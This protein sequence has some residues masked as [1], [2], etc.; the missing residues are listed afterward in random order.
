MK[1]AGGLWPEIVSFSNL[2]RAAE[3]AAAGKRSRTDVAAFLMNLELELL[4]L[5]RE[6]SQG[7]YLPGKYR[8][9]TLRDPKP[10]LISAAPFR[11]RVVHHALTQVVEPIFERRFST[12]SF[13][14]RVGL[15]THAAVEQA[16][17]GAR[18]FAYVLKCES[19]STSPPSIT[20]S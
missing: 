11:D 19:E 6:L 20:T 13:A 10:R 14:C 16:R 4:K 18:K 1:R 7:G 12:A 17:C 5:Q 9:F 2:L 3:K 15:G 8:S